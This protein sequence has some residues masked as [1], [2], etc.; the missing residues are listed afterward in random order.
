MLLRYDVV[1]IGS[2]PAGMAAAV[3]ASDKGVSVC[4]VER[5][6][7]MGGILKQCIHDGFGLI[8]FKEKLTGPEYAW[9]YEQMV[10][11]NPIDF[12]SSTFLTQIKKE[13][14]VFALSFI[15]PEK[16]VFRMEADTLIMAMG[17]R[18]R[19]DRQ[20]FLHGERPAGIF[21]AGQAQDLINLK[22]F[23]PGKKCLILG[24]GD[25]GLIMARRL[26]LEGAEVQGVYE[27]GS[28]PSGLTRN[29]VQC[30]EDYDIPLHL[31][32]SV[33]EIHGRKRVESVS[34]CEVDSNKKFIE[35]TTAKISCDCLILSVGLIPEN[36]ILAP[37]GIKMDLVT[38]GPVVDQNLETSFPGIFSCGNALLVSDLVDYVSESGHIAGESAAG[39]CKNHSI[40]KKISL[41]SAGNIHSVVPQTFTAD[42]GLVTLYLRPSKAMDKAELHLIQGEHIILN[43]KMNWLKPSEMHREEVD[44]SGIDPAGPALELSLIQG[45]AK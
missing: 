45:A 27:I 28:E 32:M 5:E 20:I 24:S 22:G 11:E 29:I 6:E 8:R 21:T 12:L 37:L 39:R 35:N 2:G 7:R 42:A 14:D 17:C 10:R 36:D 23:L 3:S 34:L 4:L 25:I 16:G 31:N 41:E 18:E 38:G 19:T 33:R 9:R 1:I 15:N 13:E 44:L 26:T 30:L 43:K 40:A